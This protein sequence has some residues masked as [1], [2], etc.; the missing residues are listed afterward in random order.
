MAWMAVGGLL[1]VTMNALMRLVTQDLE[2]LLAQFLRYFTALLIVIALALHG[3]LKRLRTQ[4]LAGQFWRGLAHTIALALFFSSLPHIPLADVTAIQFITPILVVVGAA[5]VL[6]ER[7]S[8]A[9]WLAAAIGFAGM[10]VVVGPHLGP[11]GAGFWPLVMLLSTP[12]F[13]ATFLIAKAMTRNDSG[14]VIVFWQNLTVSLFTLPLALMVWQWPS[15]EQWAWLWLCGALGTAAHGCFVR[16]FA[17]ADIS[18]VQPVRFLDLV[19]S[20]L[21]GLA[22]FGD[23]PTATALAGGATIVGATIWLARHER[24]ARQ[25]KLEEPSAHGS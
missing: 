25:L 5:L 15:G 16:A 14:T 18:S 13:A 24:R 19:W 2:P 9:R 10:L 23:W 11:G 12:F 21:L 4:N 7:V 22:L 20:S 3:P 17:L 6:R 1:L 8:G